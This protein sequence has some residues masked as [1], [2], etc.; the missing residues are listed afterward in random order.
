MRTSTSSASIRARTPEA[1]AAR[2]AAA[3][4][5][6]VRAGRVPRAPAVRAERPVLQGAAVEPAAHRPGA[7]L[8]HPA[9]RPGRTS[10]SPCSTPASRTRTRPSRFHADAFRDDHGRPVSGARRPRRSISCARPSS[11]PAS[12]FVAPHDFIWNDNAA[13]RS[14]RPRHARQRHDRTADQQRRRHGRRRLQREDHAGQGDR[15]RRGT[16]SSARPTRAPTTWW[17]GASGTRPTTARRSST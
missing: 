13:A 1:V 17:R 2:S 5:R 9:G 11:G 6:R 12:R 7:R 10:P 14:R 4:R 15:Q 16:T 3:P 8:G